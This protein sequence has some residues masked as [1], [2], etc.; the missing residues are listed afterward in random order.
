MQTEQSIVANQYASAVI[1]LAEKSGAEE[2]ILK[3]LTVL[4]NVINESKELSEILHHPSV[5]APEKKKLLADLFGNKLNELTQRL[6]D[7]L[8]D[9][10][11]LNLF[12]AI[13]EEYRNLLRAKKNIVTGT[14]SSAEALSENQLSELKDKI[15][16]KIGKQIELEVKTDKSLIGGY[17]L[18]IG[19]QVIDGSLKGR[20]QIIEKSLLSI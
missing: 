14:L 3:D 2:A 9:R 20:L 8:C 15:T 12:K 10:R 6:V 19:D 1:E 13:E 17:V 11:R 5:P 7:L 16:K 18:R 4:N